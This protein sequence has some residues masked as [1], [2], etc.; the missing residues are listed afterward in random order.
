M[1][2]HKLK[3]VMKLTQTMVYSAI[4]VYHSGVSHQIRHRVSNVKLFLQDVL[5]VQ[6]I[7]MAIQMSV[8]DALQI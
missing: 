1:K 3:D 4:D 5:N 2:L 7:I 6:L 8:K